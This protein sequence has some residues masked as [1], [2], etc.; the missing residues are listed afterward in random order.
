MHSPPHPALL[1][2]KGHYAAADVS[3]LGGT[4]GNTTV[5][6]GVTTAFHT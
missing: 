4:E 3:D 2:L 6:V 1:L 5:C